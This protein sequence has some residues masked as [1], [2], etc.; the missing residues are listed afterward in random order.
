MPSVLAMQPTEYIVNDLRMVHDGEIF[1][2]NLH[3]PEELHEG[4]QFPSAAAVAMPVFSQAPLVTMGSADEPIHILYWNK[5]TDSARSM[6]AHGIG[7]SDKGP[8]VGE[9]SVAKKS[10]GHWRV[11]LTRGLGHGENIAPLS[12]GKHQKIG[13]VIWNGSN[14]E[15]AGIKA[16]SPNWLDFH[17]E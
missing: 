9:K 12:S 15:R 17:V 16:F 2:V 14:D 5:K 3:W 4:G 8:S 10:D 6:I 1:A 13:L 7:T 11:T